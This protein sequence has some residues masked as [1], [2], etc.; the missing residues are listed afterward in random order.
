MHKLISIAKN[1]MI[2]V[3]ASL[4]L[5]GLSVADEK[6]SCTDTSA[7]EAQGRW[8]AR[9]EKDVDVEQSS[10]IPKSEW[11]A[12]KKRT[13]VYSELLRQALGEFKGYDA[14]GYRSA[15]GA[16][17]KDGPAM[18]RYQVV[19]YDFLCF[20][21]ALHGY[22]DKHPDGEYDYGDT[23]VAIQVNG[24]WDMAGPEARFIIGGKKYYQFGTPIGEIRGFP[25]FEAG[26]K[27]IVLISKPE[28]F[29]FTYASRKELLDQ[30]VASADEEWQKGLKVADLTTPIRPKEAQERDQQK[31]LEL[32]LKGAKDE[33][34][35]QKWTE[36]Y[37]KDY[38]TDEQ[39]REEARAKFNKIHDKTL[40]YL[41][42]LRATFT[43]EQLEQPAMVAGNTL[44]PDEYFKFSP[45]KQEVCGKSPSCGE[46]HGMP[47]AIPHRKYFDLD[48]PRSAPQF[49]TV[50]FSWNKYT[51]QRRDDF[52]AHFDFDKLVSL[53]GK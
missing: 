39:K 38:R 17:F 14:V 23:E 49:F 37:M 51:I 21:G 24:V 46:H 42:G 48:L 28:K 4:T 11:S 5:C 12:V 1:A 34:Q 52:F 3:L 40:A 22:L 15:A 44:Y 25:A 30:M 36:R 50:S 32:F 31:G 35:K 18:Y 53:L 19:M 33:Q 16:L 27:W 47:F 9:I 6:I 41:D 10:I 8:G 20:N 29:P 45:T 26:N 7:S 13:D 43:P 2:T